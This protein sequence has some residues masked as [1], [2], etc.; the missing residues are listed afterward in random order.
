[1]KKLTSLLCALVLVLSLCGISTAA[2]DTWTQVASEE[3]LN[4]ALAAGDTNIR[5]TQSINLENTISVRKAVTLDLGGN[6]ITGAQTRNVFSL[7][8]SDMEIT[9]QNGSITGMNGT[10]MMI[11]PTSGTSSK[12]TLNQVVLTVEGDGKY[13]PQSAINI[14]RNSKG[15]LDLIVED[16]VVQGGSSTSYDG[17]DGI[18]VYKEDTTTLQVIHSKVSGG[19]GKDGKKGSSI[20]CNASSVQRFEV[21]VQNSLLESDEGFFV[22]R[23]IKEETFVYISDGSI[24][25]GENA[26][27]YEPNWDNLTVTDTVFAVDQFYDYYSLSQEAEQ[28]ILD[29]IGQVPTSQ[30]EPVIVGNP[31]ADYSAVDAA[32]EKVNALD[33]QLYQD[34]SGV[35]LAVDGVVRGLY[36]HQQE[37]VDAMAQAIEQAIAALVYK[38]ADY[39]AVDQAIEKAQALDPEKYVDFSAVE[40]AVAAVER[41]L[42]ITRQDDVDAM[43]QAIEDAI[44]GLEWIPPTITAGANGVWTVGS[45]AGLSFTSDADYEDFLRVLVDGAE[46]NAADYTVEVG[47]TVVTLKAAYLNTLSVGSHTLDIVSINGSAHTTFTIQPSEGDQETDVPETGDTASGALWFAGWLLMSSAVAGWVLFRKNQA[48]NR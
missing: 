14:N 24:F 10:G 4:Q 3:E 33:A 22:S 13:S 36:V 20:N 30:E 37:E 25:Q 15:H 28:A 18:S 21:W 42:D 45:E 40:Q 1:M 46:L 9:I 32:L 2:Q 47:S 44:A 31:V 5:L 6:T 48:S 16:C 17:G 41:G 19:A 38:D 34:F 35:Q 23:D 8:P 7:Y 12:V 39:T 27:Q 26:F 11:Y 43:A 29:K